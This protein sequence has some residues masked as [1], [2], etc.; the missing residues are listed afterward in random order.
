[1]PTGLQ[2]LLDSLHTVFIGRR[3]KHVEAHSLPGV[4]K[5]CAEWIY[6][7]QMAL[8]ADPCQRPKCIRSEE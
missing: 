4:V 2:E 3:V 5:R 8:H 6:A 1:M 7:V